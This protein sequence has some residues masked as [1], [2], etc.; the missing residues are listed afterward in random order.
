[1]KNKE[2]LPDVKMADAFLIFSNS[3]VCQQNKFHV[4]TAEYS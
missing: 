4:F 1:M 2:H 3:I